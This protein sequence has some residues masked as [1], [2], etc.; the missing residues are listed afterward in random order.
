MPTIDQIVAQIRT[1]V[2]GK[3]VRENIA[4]GIEKCYLD[5]AGT[6][7]HTT[8]IVNNLDQETPGKVLD[9]SQG[10]VLKNR[11]DNSTNIT[12]TRIGSTEDYTMVVSKS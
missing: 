9:A 6:T 2:Y 3:D 4:E 10:K 8:D 12:V 7:L 11:I 5:F 1:A